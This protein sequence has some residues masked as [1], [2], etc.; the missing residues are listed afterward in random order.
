MKL[1]FTILIICTI[2][3]GC[4]NLIQSPEKKGDLI[5][6]PLGNLGFGADTLSCIKSCYGKLT[7][8]KDSTFVINNYSD[9]NSFRNYVSC[10][11]INSWP[12]IDFEKNTMLAGIKVEGSSCGR[13]LTQDFLITFLNSDYKFIVAI[14][15][16]GYAEMTV[17]I[18]WALV[19]KIGSG[20][21]VKFVIE[22]KTNT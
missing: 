4:D 17:I 8:R 6:R 9:Y 11:D 10:L 13:L 2:S 3:I 19:D 15:P 22:H 12:S 18:Y 5:I 16:G 14:K 7:E 1:L 21:S 20:S